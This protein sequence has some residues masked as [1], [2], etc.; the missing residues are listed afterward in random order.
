MKNKEQPSPNKLFISKFNKANWACIINYKSYLKLQY[1]QINKINYSIQNLKLF[2]PLKLIK[3]SLS[4][5]DLVKIVNFIGI[6]L[7]M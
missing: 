2:T 5:I 4:R 6:K 3:T 7:L 1:L